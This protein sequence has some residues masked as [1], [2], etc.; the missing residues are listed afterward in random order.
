MRPPGRTRRRGQPLVALVLVL[1]SWVGARAAL[2]ENAKFN[3]AQP[4]GV[5]IN[6]PRSTAQSAA[7]QNQTPAVNIPAQ[8]H[9]IVPKMPE[10][11]VSVVPAAPL[12]PPNTQAPPPPA[13]VLDQ[14]NALQQATVPSTTPLTP[15]VAFGHQEL[16]LAGMNLLSSEPAEAMAPPSLLRPLL[17]AVL[18]AAARVP[19][20]RSHWSVDA[21]LLLRPGG[22]FFNAPGA[23]LPGVVVPTGFYGGSQGGLIIRYFLA[24]GSKFNPAVYLRGSSGIER[25]RGEELA[26]GFSMRPIPG[27]PLRV[28]AEGRATRTIN[29]TIMRWSANYRRRGCRW[30]CAAKPIFRPVMLA[31]AGRPHL[32]MARRGLSV[33]WSTLAGSRCGPAAGSGAGR[34]AGRAGWMLAPPQRSR[35]GLERR[36][37]GFLQTIA[38]ALPA[39]LRPDRVRL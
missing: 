21:W 22:N 17:P 18:A 33:R 3:L 11:P 24:P 28:L 16:W 14:A 4:Q 31:A 32:S 25:P 12:A 8:S 15:R 1:V 36:S 10:R 38:G 9:R 23:G 29:G 27:L 19:A 7:L 39:T 26:A 35:S 6:P 30:A 5:P 2:W 13:S 34:S 20:G 37:R